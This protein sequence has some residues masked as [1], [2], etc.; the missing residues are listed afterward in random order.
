MPENRYFGEIAYQY[1][2]LKERGPWFNWLYIDFPYL[3]KIAAEEGWNSQLI[4]Q[5]D[6]DQYLVSLT[7]K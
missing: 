3:K 4:Y 5:D 1:E 2:Y 7:L 6:M